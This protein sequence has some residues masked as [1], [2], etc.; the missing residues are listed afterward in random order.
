MAW[1][2]V[3]Y[4]QQRKYSFNFME[5]ETML[6]KIKFSYEESEDRNNLFTSAHRKYVCIIKYNGKQYTF[7]YQC[8]PIYSKPNLNDC[9]DSLL[10]DG[11]SYSDSKDIIDF[12]NE[13]GYDI[14]EN[15]AE[16]KRIYNACKKTWKALNRLFTED[17]ISEIEKEVREF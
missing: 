17:E 2:V 6:E 12:A 11:F 14:Y 5:G 9:M 3:I 16:V 7:D 10:L 1:Y 8:N 4:N 13:F 15:K